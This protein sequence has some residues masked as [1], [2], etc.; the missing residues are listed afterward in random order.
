MDQ[1]TLAAKRRAVALCD[2]LRFQQHEF[3][4]A[5]TKWVEPPFMVRQAHHERLSKWPF[6]LSL[7]NGNGRSWFDRLTTNGF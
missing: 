7:S 1:G 6:A 3:E 2:N 5:I 4:S